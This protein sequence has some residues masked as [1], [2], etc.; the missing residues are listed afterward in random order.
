MKKI[1]LILFVFSLIFYNTQ[2]SVNAASSIPYCS[3]YYVSI[4]EN[5]SSD[6]GNFLNTFIKAPYQEA[7]N[8]EIIDDSWVSFTSYNFT[9]YIP[10]FA[11]E[12]YIDPSDYADGSFGYY[13][14][15]EYDKDF[16]LV[17]DMFDDYA[18]E[19]E[20]TYDWFT[21]TLELNLWWDS[22]SR[23][24]VVYDYLGEGLYGVFSW[25]SDD[26]YPTATPHMLINSYEDENAIVG[27]IVHE[28]FHAVQYGYV[29]NMSMLGFSSF[30]EGSATMI[31]SKIPGNYDLS[32]MGLEDIAALS[33]PEFSVFGALSE[34]NDSD[35]Y[36]SFLWYS[37]LY[38]YYGQ[39]IV[40]DILEAFSSLE[41]SGFEESFIPYYSY[42]AVRDA[43]E[44]QGEDVKDVYGEFVIKNYEHDT[45]TDR[46]FLPDVKILNSHDSPSG[47]EDVDASAPALFGTNYIEFDTEDKEGYLSIDF[48]GNTDAEFYISFLP[49]RDSGSVIDSDVEKY[50]VEVDDG[51]SFDIMLD[52]YSSI[53][54]LVSP[55]DTTSATLLSS[56]D[57][58]N[59]FTFPYSYAFEYLDS[60]PEEDATESIFNDVNSYTSNAEAISY[61]KDNGIISGYPDGSF[62]PTNYLNRAELLKILVEGMGYTPD[63]TSYGNCF[64]DVSNDWYAKY[65]CFAK[66]NG[67]IEGYPDGLFKP[68]NNVNKVEA[69]KMLLEIFG[70][71]T[72]EPLVEPYS[73]VP[74]AQWFTKYVYMAKVLG[75]LEEESLY[76]PSENITRAG[77]SENIYRLLLQL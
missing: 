71:E 8:F 10:F 61:L 54:M 28:M 20:D 45:Y 53:V 12:Y 5:P 44:K 67:W 75:L 60:I 3:S 23:I 62:K 7:S 47:Y 30:A 24:P 76:Y 59:D 25:G 37:Y 6:L 38:Q 77:I 27:T 64:P 29:D 15:L 31:E 11:I 48:G 55:V 57:V 49:T 34:W 19:F 50:F 74:L 73:D 43:L 39:N 51:A 21:D 58:F 14:W 70:Q 4:C 26:Y 33:S 40:K 46:S 42:L 2:K 63:E 52:D 69:I 13:D 22:G 18:E 65:V 32:Y 9:Y 17:P 41:G 35:K 68:S 1:I 56:E 66:E 16:N 36:G 72:S